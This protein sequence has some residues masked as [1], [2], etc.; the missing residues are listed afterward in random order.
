M[1]KDN[2]GALFKNERKE[3]DNH[4]DFNGTATINGVEMWVSA[5]IKVY[6]KQGEKRKYYSLS[7]RT[8]EPR[9]QGPQTRAGAEK[10]VAGMDDDIPW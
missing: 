4:P 8:K 9:T 7:F 3:T 2:Q 10:A 1:S 5:W 6:E